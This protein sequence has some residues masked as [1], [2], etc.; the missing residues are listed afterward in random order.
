[1]RHGEENRDMR[2]C[3]TSRHVRCR[4]GEGFDVSLLGLPEADRQHV[5]HSAFFPR[6]DVEAN[7]VSRTYRRASDSGFAVT[8][9]FCPNCGSTV[10]WEPER[11]PEEIA[12]A[13]GSFADP[14][15]PAPSQSVYNERRHSWVPSSN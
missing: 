12:V 1:M 4:A 13:V 5:R 2:L 9:Y 6:K 14:T 15:F 7:G 3:A 8:F 10:Y 11:R